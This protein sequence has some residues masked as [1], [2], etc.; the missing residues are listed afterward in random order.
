MYYFYI[1]ENT[2]GGLYF[3]STNHLEKRKDRHN[4]GYIFSTKGHVWEIIYYEAY[5]SEKDAREREKKIKQHGQAK[6]HLKKRI[7][8]SRLWKN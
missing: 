2:E 1:I 3:G 5:K 8:N 7:K 4:S 6:T